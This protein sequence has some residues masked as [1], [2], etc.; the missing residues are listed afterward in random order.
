MGNSAMAKADATKRE[1][2]TVYL[3]AALRTKLMVYAA[4]RRQQ[5]S[6]VVA[7]AVQRFLEGK[8]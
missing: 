8:R 3:D 6:A 1:R 5:I 7:T 4:E 2:M